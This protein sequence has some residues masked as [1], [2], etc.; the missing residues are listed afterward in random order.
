MILN[1]F[2]EIIEFLKFNLAQRLEDYQSRHNR[3]SLETINLNDYIITH[4]DH[5]I[6]SIDRY[7][8]PDRY[9]KVNSLID[10]LPHC[11]SLLEL[12][13]ILKTPQ[14]SFIQKALFSKG[15][16]RLESFAHLVQYGK[17]NVNMNICPEAHYKPL[18]NL[19]RISY[20]DK[21][22][23]FASW[24]AYN[25]VFSDC[26][27]RMAHYVLERYTI[28]DE[29]VITEPADTDLADFIQIIR[30]HYHM[31]AFAS[32]GWVDK[33]NGLIARFGFSLV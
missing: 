25:Q 32:D 10:S 22:K 7:S 20:N 1:S 30:T 9:G 33:M 13:S 18:I 28:I 27:H 4:P 6:H 15:L 5:N 12:F 19:D 17:I 11:E 29:S 3:L 14:F 23:V 21:I 16:E 26:N 24:I 8:E 2:S 31:Y